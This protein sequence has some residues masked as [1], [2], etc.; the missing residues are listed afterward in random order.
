MTFKDKLDGWIDRFNEWRLTHMTDRRFMLILSIPTGFLAGAA[1]VIIKKLAHGIRDLV[2]HHVINASF[3]YSHLLY[4]VCPAI[5]IL[6]TILFCKYLLKK[7]VG[8]GIPGILYAISKNKGKVSRSS[9]WS[10]IITSALTVGFGG[11]VGLEGP[12]VST[13]GSIGSNIAQALKLDYKHTIQLIGMGGAAALA[14]IFQAPITGI[15]FALEVFMID[16]S[17]NALVPIIC[18]SFV[19]ILTAYFFLG[20]TVEYPAAIAEGFIPSNAL[21]YIGLG[22]FAGLVSAYFL[23]VSF[24]VE[25]SFK[26]VRSPWT[27]F[28]IGGTLLGVLIFLFPAL[29]GE[30]Y[31]AINS[32]LRGDYSPVF[33]NAWFAR[34]KDYDLVVI[35]LFAGMILLKA[36]ATAFTFGAGGVGGTFAPA[37]F[38]GAFT[39]LFFA[40]TVNYLG[41]GNLDPAKFALVGMSGLVAGM[42]HAPLTGIFLIAE[43]T[44]GYALIVPL[45]IVSALAYAINRLFFKHSIYTNAVAEKGVE[46]TH[47]K[48]KSILNMMA[49]NQLIENNFSPIHPDA[50]FRDLLPLVSSSKRN[51]FPVVDKEGFFCGHVLFDDVRAILFDAS[52]YDQSIQ[53]FAVLPDYVIHPEEPMEEIVFK[54]QE[55]GKYNIPVIQGGKYLGYISR[56]NVFSAYRNM[57][58]EISED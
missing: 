53:N 5:G 35:I 39:G 37:L 40:T 48:D 32:A 18:S 24:S 22:L 4:F 45:M 50:T 55:S 17:L 31:E 7:E 13:G 43:I 58:S 23:K 42:L 25:K 15:V 12:S 11:S 21:Y 34:F 19:A 29:Y 20:Q 57:M 8:H 54:F 47:N 3:S 16:L 33:G 28:L 38:I 56:A 10:S 51:I 26:K 27:R 9:T 14:A 36:F 41:I 2:Y 46:V 44:N 49:I 1:A 52:Y 30:G 6:L